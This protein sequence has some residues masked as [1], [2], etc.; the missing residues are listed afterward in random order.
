MATTDFLLRP[1]PQSAR[2]QTPAGQDN[3]MSQ[4]PASTVSGDTFSNLYAQQQRAVQAH[5]QQVQQQTQQRQAASVQEKQQQTA[6]QTVAK[7]TAQPPQD[8]PAAS[9]R[10]PVKRDSTQAGQGSDAEGAAQSSTQSVS[11]QSGNLLPQDHAQLPEEPVDELMDPLLLMAMTATPMDYVDAA[12]AAVEAESK[13]LFSSAQSIGSVGLTTE[14]LEVDELQ[15]A[16]DEDAVSLKDFSEP[17]QQAST[18]KAALLTAAS[19]KAGEVL[20]D[21]A[22]PDKNNTAALV[23]STKVAPDS[24]LN[25]KAV[26]P[27][28]T[29]RSDMLPRQDTLLPAQSTRQVPGAAI[30]MQQPGW[31]Q[32]VTDKVMWMSSQNLKSAEIKLDPAELGRLDI[33]VSVG[34]EHTQITFTSAHAGVRDSLETQMHRLRE[35]LAQQG[36]QNVD[37]NVSD[38]SQ[39][40]HTESREHAVAQ[41]RSGVD[42]DNQDETVQ[43]VTPIR[44][45]QDGRLGLVDYYA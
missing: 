13:V 29:V 9:P 26:T 12:P 31:T 6:R 18:D 44:A 41:G 16:A 43:H 27:T 28:E 42:G 2:T 10:E 1:A 39:Q 15:L 25:N 4:R 21:K 34:Q 8:K 32:Q 40:Q 38:Q 14:T 24:L 11:E 30:A 17:E 45:Q 19:G 20:V 35:L 37:V 3:T 7:N 5:Q 36:M 33:K 22:T 23:E